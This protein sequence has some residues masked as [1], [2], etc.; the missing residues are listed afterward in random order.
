[1]SI[2]HLSLPLT[3]HDICKQ[4]NGELHA[5]KLCEFYDIA[6]A[7]HCRETIAEEVRDKDRSNYC[8]YFKPRENAYSNTGANAAELAKEKLAALFGKK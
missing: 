6:K 3:R 1:M 4:C 5:C 2:A 8:D 7:K